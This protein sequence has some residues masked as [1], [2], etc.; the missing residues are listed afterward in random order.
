MST[1]PK[2][3]GDA[4]P[5]RRSFL[6]TVT[7][8][9]LAVAGAATAGSS[10]VFLRPRV[11]YGPPARMAVGK[12]DTYTSG[13]QVVLPEAKLVIRRQGNKIAAIST[14]CTHLGCTVNP[15]ETG[16]DCPCHGSQYDDRGDV[17]GGPAP[18]SLAWYRCSLAPNGELVVD[19]HDQ[20]EP[21]TFLEVQS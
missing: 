3:P 13:S 6:T 16:F 8:T 4:Q 18:K 19:K 7:G 1:D 10:L 11:T 20:V 17:I 21:D 2:K 9:A 5:G 14:V 15:T 12:P